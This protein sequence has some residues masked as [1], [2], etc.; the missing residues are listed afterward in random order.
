MS[1]KN[2]FRNK[3][4][5]YFFQTDQPPG[6]DQLDH[7]PTYDEVVE[8]GG[9]FDNANDGANQVH[10]TPDFSELDEALSLLHDSFV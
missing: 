9:N 5:L 10:Q 6:Y 1:H 2:Y 4:F 7:P 3:F 8:A